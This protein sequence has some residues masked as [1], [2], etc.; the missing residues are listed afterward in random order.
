[1]LWEIER[2]MKNNYFESFFI[3]FGMFNDCL[4]QLG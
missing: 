1:M 3:D 4:L 2:E